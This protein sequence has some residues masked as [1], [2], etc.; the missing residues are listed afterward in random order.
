MQ[1][2]LTKIAPLDQNFITVI[3]LPRNDVTENQTNPCNIQPTF[4]IYES[5]SSYPRREG[6][7][8]GENSYD[9]LNREQLGTTMDPENLMTHEE[10][11][12]FNYSKLELADDD[13]KPEKKMQLMLP[14]LRP[15]H[16]GQIIYIALV[17]IHLQYN[18][19]C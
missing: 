17:H 2:T 8:Q 11:K 13:I 7:K 10:A 6:E 14:P 16:E 19:V 1:E 12:M 3:I 4:A 15:I 5:I 18:A 9:A